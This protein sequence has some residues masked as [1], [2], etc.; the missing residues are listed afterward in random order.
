MNSLFFF[1]TFSAEHCNMFV[2][3]QKQYHKMTMDEFVEFFQ[4]CHSID[5]N[6]CEQHKCEAAEEE[7]VRRITERRMLLTKNVLL[8]VAKTPQVTISMISPSM[9]DKKPLLSMQK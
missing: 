6:I 8:F 4:I 3:Q 5:Q 2:Q 1:N 9:P 7:N